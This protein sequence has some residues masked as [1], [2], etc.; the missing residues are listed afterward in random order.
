M[1]EKISPLK[2][3][4]QNFISD[5]NLL[6]K[7]CGFADIKPDDHVLEIGPGLGSLTEVL[8]R[9][10]GRVLAIEKDKRLIEYLRER[11]S[12]MNS[13][14]L[15]DGD[16]LD[17]SFSCYAQSRKLKIVSNL[18]YNI[19]TQI[20]IKII[21]ERQILEN[22][23]VMLQ[24]EVADRV[25]SAPGNRTYGGLSVLLQA[26]F[27]VERVMIIQ[28]GAF[29]PRPKV[30]SAVVRLTPL[31]ETV[32]EIAD[33]DTFRKVVRAAFSSRRKMLRNSL[34]SQFSDEHICIVLGRTGI[35]GNKRAEALNVKEF[36][37][38]SNEFYQLQQLSNNVSRSC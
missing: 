36:I 13:I 19:S 9:S 38:M 3:F 37:I 29:Y 7:I 18:P 25:C 21:D 31:S 34:G 23:V 24:K 2:K 28:P 20:L 8:G 22:V 30:Q 32:T 4:G 10:S 1:T 5:K 17:K 27:N 12:S 26:F 11:F 35:E 16:I 15:I 33:Q 6:K 14:E